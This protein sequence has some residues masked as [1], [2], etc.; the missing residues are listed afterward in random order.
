MR[1][2]HEGYK[3]L[4]VFSRACRLALIL[5]HLTKN[6]SSDERYLL[7]DQIRRSSRSICVN[8]AEAYRKRQYTKYFLSKLSDADGETGETIL[9]LDFS[10]DLGWLSTEIPKDLTNRYL[11]IG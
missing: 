1:N 3:D 4:I 6:Y 10:K 11:E 8:I 9:R 5:S 7:I 2:E